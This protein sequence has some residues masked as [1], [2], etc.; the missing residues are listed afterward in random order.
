MNSPIA[1]MRSCATPRPCADPFPSARFLIHGGE[2][3]FYCVPGMAHI[4]RWKSGRGYLP[5]SVA[6][7]KLFLN[8]I[9]QLVSHVVLRTQHLEEGKSGNAFFLLIAIR[10]N[11]IGTAMPA[12]GGNVGLIGWRG[13]SLSKFRTVRN[14][15]G[16]LG[17]MVE[18]SYFLD[19]NRFLECVSKVRDV[20]FRADQVAVQGEK[21][22]ACWR[23]IKVFQRRNAA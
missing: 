3:G 6:N 13:D 4:Y 1:S 14:G 9:I 12:T 20:Q 11:S 22:Q 7:C 17:K 16:G 5:P 23:Q 15:E 8:I 19:A 10:L 18:H 2:P 21:T